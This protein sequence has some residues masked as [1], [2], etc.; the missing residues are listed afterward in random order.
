MRRWLALVSSQSQ[1]ALMWARLAASKPRFFHGTSSL[2]ASFPHLSRFFLNELNT[3]SVETWNLFQQAFYSLPRTSALY[4]PFNKD[5]SVH[6]LTFRAGLYNPTL[7]HDFP[8]DRLITE[9]DGQDPLFLTSLPFGNSC[10]SLQHLAL[11]EESAW[12]IAENSLFDASLKP[13]FSERITI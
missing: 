2:D 13:P 6:S 12:S 4:F 9:L 10:V 1:Q 3:V 5:L 7:H 11:G 8:R